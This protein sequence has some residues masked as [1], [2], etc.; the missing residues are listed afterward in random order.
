MHFLKT[1]NVHTACI[2]HS[3]SID[4]WGPA[5]SERPPGLIF[6]IYSSFSLGTSLPAN[7]QLLSKTYLCN[8]EYLLLIYF[9]QCMPRLCVSCVYTFLHRLLGSSNTGTAVMCL[10]RHSKAYPRPSVYSPS[11]FFQK[12][13]MNISQSRSQVPSAQTTRRSLV[14]ADNSSLS[15]SCILIHLFWGEFTFYLDPRDTHPT[16]QNSEFHEAPPAQCLSSRIPRPSII[17]MHTRLCAPN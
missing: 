11:V 16:Q 9:Y 1:T 7:L 17:S 6:C 4:G 15:I 10:S 2:W 3:D 5:G 12:S 8:L 13:N 14:R